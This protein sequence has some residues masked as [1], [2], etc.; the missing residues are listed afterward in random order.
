MQQLNRQQ[1]NHVTRYSR[2]GIG[3]QDIENL[4]GIVRR[5]QA[6][7]MTESSKVG[8]VTFTVWV[9]VPAKG[10]T[11]R[12]R[13][14]GIL[15]ETAE[16]NLAVGTQLHFSGSIVP[17]RITGWVRGTSYELVQSR[18]PLEGVEQA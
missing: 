7:E 16:R 2:I 13:Y 18:L 17:D 1:F 6:K 4:F 11:L 3:R 5:V 9:F 14:E 12:V 15:A 10:V 8:D